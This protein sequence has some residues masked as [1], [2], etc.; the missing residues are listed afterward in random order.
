[1][2]HSNRIGTIPVYNLRDSNFV[3]LAEKL[4]LYEETLMRSK[5]IRLEDSNPWAEVIHRSAFN[6]NH[7]DHYIHVVSEKKALIVVPVSSWCCP[8]TH[9][10]D[11]HLRAIIRWCFASLLQ[12]CLHNMT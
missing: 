4:S 1:M 12:V 8:P 10:M 2:R 7:A 3:S 9:K 6:K 5:G 11:I